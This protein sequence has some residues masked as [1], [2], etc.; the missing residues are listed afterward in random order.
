MAF[1]Y[2]G[3]R[4]S[5]KDEAA[6]R[7]AGLPTTAAP[8]T[9][10]GAEFVKEIPLGSAALTK[11]AELQPPADSKGVAP[12]PCGTDPRTSV[13]YRYSPQTGQPCEGLQQERVVIRQAVRQAP[14]RQAEPPREPT[15]E[16]QAVILAYRREQTS[17]VSRQLF[18]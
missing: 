1:A 6:A 3:Y 7:R 9:Q 14:T 17:E 13:P 2:G 4:R 15:P 18:S 10:A 12:A 11:A 16:E 5:A 8:A